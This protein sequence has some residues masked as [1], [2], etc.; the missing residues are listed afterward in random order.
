[1]TPMRPLRRGVRSWPVPSNWDIDTCTWTYG[2]MRA[3]GDMDYILHKG[4]LPVEA[5]REKLGGDY[6]LVPFADGCTAAVRAD[7][8]G[9]EPNQHWPVL[10]GDVLLGKFVGGVLLGV[11]GVKGGAV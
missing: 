2:W 5:I 1:M 8:T 6:R 7:S 9:L 10:K 3:K 4:P 11:L